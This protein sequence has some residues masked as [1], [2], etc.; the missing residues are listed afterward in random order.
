MSNFGQ[1]FPL[2][3]NGDGSQTLKIPEVKEDTYFDLVDTVTDTGSLVRSVLQDR[4]HYIGKSVP[5]VGERM[6]F[7]D[8]ADS[9]S[10]GVV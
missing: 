2:V 1:M 3:P 7:K 9:Y 4:S 6:A 5:V 10:K 8:M